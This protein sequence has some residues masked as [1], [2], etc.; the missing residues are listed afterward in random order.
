MLFL[1]FKRKNKKWLCYWF[2]LNEEWN[3][4]PTSVDEYGLERTPCWHLHTMGSRFYPCQWGQFTPCINMALPI[5]SRL[6]ISSYMGCNSDLV[7]VMIIVWVRV[8]LWPMLL[9]SSYIL[10]IVNFMLVV[11]RKKKNLSSRI[12]LSDQFHL[13]WGD[14]VLLSDL[15]LIYL[16][17]ICF[18]FLL[19]IQMSSTG[20][21]FS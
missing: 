2:V 8:L 17:A 5:V 15:T 20:K 19:M 21:S 10:V 1:C 3:S 6:S 16:T 7:M 12:S 14:T 11:N 9:F 18:S 4:C 13:C